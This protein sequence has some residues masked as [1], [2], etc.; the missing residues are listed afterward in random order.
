MYGSVAI[1]LIIPTLNEE[2]N[3]PHI[4][5]QI[6]VWIDEVILVDGHSTD[7]TVA[8]AREL[9]PDIR[10]VYQQGRGK[11]AALRSGFA[12]AT[13]DII[14]MIDADGSTNPH[15]IPA[16]VGALLAGADFVKGSRFMQG[17]GTV[18][19]TLFRILGHWCLLQL[20]NTLFGAKYTDLCYGYSAFWR[21][22]L[23]Q[24]QLD[25][26]GFEIETQMNVRVLQAEARVVEV[27]SFELERIHGIGRLRAIPDGWRVLKTILRERLQPRV[28]K[29][30]QRR[31]FYS[32][33]YN[34]TPLPTMPHSMQQESQV[35]LKRAVGE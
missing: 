25:S 29:K 8:V 32:E 13:G 16:F 34:I 11:G 23:P 7:Q 30:V 17:G 3:L 28:K 9:L 33:T 27:P 2:K 14:V 35:L 24:L 10:V 19:M 26:N 20:V 21:D 6:P 4:L 18:D 31:A 22:L 15:E 5:P 12:A 1:S